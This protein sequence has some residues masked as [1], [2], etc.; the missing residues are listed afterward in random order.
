M[1]RQEQ[2]DAEYMK[3]ALALARL[4]SSTGEVP[5]GA[6]VVQNDI[7]I[8]TGFNQTIADCDPSAHAEVLALRNAAQFIANHRLSQTTL[9][10]TLE[11]CLMCCGCLQHARVD[12]LVFGAREPRTGSVVSVNETLAD[13]NA[14]H[15]IAVSEGVLA[16]K[17]SQLLQQFFQSRRL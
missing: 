9:Y 16:E 15:R 2:I 12:R 3:Q 6:L 11:P 5:V 7:V 10:V 14:L 8:G 13:P 1:T 17:C 4:A